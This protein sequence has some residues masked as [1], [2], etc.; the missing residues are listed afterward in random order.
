MKILKR[1]HFNTDEE[2]LNWFENWELSDEMYEYLKQG[3]PSLYKIIK[4]EWK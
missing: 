4:I 1:E 2:Y 3:F